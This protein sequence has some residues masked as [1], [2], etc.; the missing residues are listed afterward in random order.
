M[1][2]SAGSSA[3]VST[4]SKESKAYLER[5]A[6]ELGR[7]WSIIDCDFLA[8]ETTEKYDAIVIMGVIEHL[9]ITELFCAS[10]RRS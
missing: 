9:P 1:P 8:Y 5:R 10:S 3:P 6:A 4:I 7:D 2:L